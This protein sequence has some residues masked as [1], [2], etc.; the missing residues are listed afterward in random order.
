MGKINFRNIAKI[1]A[2][3]LAEKKGKNILL[4]DVR[5]MS[6]SV[7]YFIIASGTSDIHLRTL[8]DT[9]EEKICIPVYKREVSPRTNWAVLDYGSV[10]VHV[11]LEDAR[12]FF[13]LEKLWNSAKVVKIDG[14]KAK[15]AKR[16]KK[17]SR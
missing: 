9:V 17:R 8:I 7:D 13:N 11:F 4:L 5:K 3:A 6:D 14:R 10:M 12:I 16:D 1:A 2:E 15:N